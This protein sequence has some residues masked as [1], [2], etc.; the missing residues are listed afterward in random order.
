MPIKGLN[1]PTVIKLSATSSPFLYE[2]LGYA[3]T[4]SRLLLSL[5]AAFT[6]RTFFEAAYLIASLTLSLC[7]EKPLPKL[8][9]IISAPLSAAY[10][11]PSAMS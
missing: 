4:T 11:I 7:G 8:V 3:G 9:F 10:I 5:P 1:A 2:S 6:M